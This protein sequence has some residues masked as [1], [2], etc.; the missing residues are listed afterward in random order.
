MERTISRT[1]KMK[2]TFTSLLILFACMCLHAQTSSKG[3]SSA[4]GVIKRFCGNSNI[5]LV[6]K[7]ISSSKQA[8]DQFTYHVDNK[9]QLTVQGNTPVA[10]CRG[11]YD[12]IRSNGYGINSW[13]GNRLNLPAKLQPQAPKTVTSPFRHHYYY[14]VVTFGYTNPYW[15]WNRW[16]QEID[17]M[18]LHGMDMPLALVA[19]EAISARVWKK[20]G[21]TDDEIQRYFVGP[22]HLPWMR[23]G[24]IAQRSGCPATQDSFAHAVAWH[25]THLSGICR[26]S[27]T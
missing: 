15:D 2:K 24:N 7:C 26:F 18:A 16:E 25:E 3:V 13:S 22:A 1:N 20:L 21:L 12:Y 27:A 11:F 6:L 8:T 17:W 5:N 9:G 23:M 14:N 4:N 10:I 19:N